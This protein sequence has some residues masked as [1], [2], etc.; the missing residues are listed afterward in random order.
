MLTITLYQIPLRRLIK[1]S[2]IGA[3]LVCGLTGFLVKHS[4]YFERGATS[5][6]ARFDYWRAAVQT[7]KTHPIF[8]S[9]PGTFSVSYKQRKAP[10][11]EMALLAHND[12]LEQ[13]SDSG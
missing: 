11:S 12:Y 2:L 13:A 7:F 10:E 9:G 3:V 6:G 5:V 8:G 1:F 4:A